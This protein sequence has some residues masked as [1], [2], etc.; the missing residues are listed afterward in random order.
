MEKIQCWVWVKRF[1]YINVT[2][3]N[4]QLV[5]QP[6]SKGIYWYILESVH[7][8]VN[9]AIINV[10]KKKVWRSICWLIC[11]KFYLF[12]YLIFS[13]IRRLIWL[14]F[15][16]FRNDCTFSVEWHLNVYYIGFICNCI[17]LAQMKGIQWVWLAKLI[18]IISLCPSMLNVIKKKWIFFVFVSLFAIYKQIL[19]NLAWNTYPRV[20]NYLGKPSCSNSHPLTYSKN[21]HLNDFPPL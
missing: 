12:L 18:G 5:I 8:L 16:K 2:F 10:I 17:Y 11:E 6:T 15:S 1:L 21:N 14:L 9:F 7:L 13:F 3:V 4:I 20:F 19:L